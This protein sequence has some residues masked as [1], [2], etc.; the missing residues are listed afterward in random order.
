MVVNNST[1][2]FSPR[3]STD[4]KLPLLNAA[5]TLCVYKLL[6]HTNIQFLNNEIKYLKENGQF[7]GST[8]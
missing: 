5:D 2:S 7:Q 4:L 6:E 8:F 1:I 3:V